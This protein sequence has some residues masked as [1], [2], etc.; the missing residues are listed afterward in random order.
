MSG[1]VGATRPPRVATLWRDTTGRARRVAA[2]F[3]ATV[4]DSL[5]I[6]GRWSAVIDYGGAVDS[7]WTRVS[8]SY[9]GYATPRR[10]ERARWA[11]E[12][13]ELLESVRE[14]WAPTT[15]RAVECKSVGPLGGQRGACS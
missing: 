10:A 5:T 14:Q 4:R 15:P 11:A 1:P 6:G 12:A 7:A 9:M 2:S 13:S 8:Y 3:V